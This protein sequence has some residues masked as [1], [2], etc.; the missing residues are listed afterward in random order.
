MDGTACLRWIGFGVFSVV[1]IGLALVGSGLLVENL[2][3][4]SCGC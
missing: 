3:I 4:A 2:L 1:V